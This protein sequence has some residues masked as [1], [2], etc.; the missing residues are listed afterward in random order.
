M[1]KTELKIASFAQGQNR[2]SLKKINDLYHFV[3]ST[4]SVTTFA[5]LPQALE[6]FNAGCKEPEPCV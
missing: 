6:A 2:R 1:K 5:F 4:G 3:D